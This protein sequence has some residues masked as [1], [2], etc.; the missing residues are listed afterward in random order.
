M[1]CSECRGYH[2]SYCPCCD[3]SGFFEQQ[4]VDSL[5]EVIE[6]S[7]KK[8]NSGEVDH[9]DTLWDFAYP[10]ILK[11]TSS[12]GEFDTYLESFKTRISEFE[13]FKN[14]EDS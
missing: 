13:C 9:T 11:L 4:M 12:D 2:V 5:A 6:E 8:I 1:S 3:N 14:L 7:V 10:E